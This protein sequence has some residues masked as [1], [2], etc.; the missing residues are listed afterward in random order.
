MFELFLRKSIAENNL[1]QV[2]YKKKI[3][4]KYLTDLKRQIY[5]I[6]RIISKCTG[7]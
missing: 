2:E 3:I 5:L 4:R 1:T 6:L 7:E